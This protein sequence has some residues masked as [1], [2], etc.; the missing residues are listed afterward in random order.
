MEEQAGA[1]QP[2]ER[3]RARPRRE[4]LDGEDAARRTGGA[5]RRR[6]GGHGR[7]RRRQRQPGSA[8]R[9]SRRRCPSRCRRCPD[10][11]RR[12][13]PGCGIPGST[14]GRPIWSA[15]RPPPVPVR[16]HPDARERRD[17][18]AA[19]HRNLDDPVRVHDE[20]VV[21][22]HDEV[23]GRAEPDRPETGVVRYGN[24]GFGDGPGARSTAV[25]FVSSE[26]SSRPRPS[27]ARPHRVGRGVGEVAL[28]DRRADRR[29]A[30][31]RRC[32][33]CRRRGCPG[34][35]SPAR[36]ATGSCRRRR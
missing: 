12:R 19:R 11:C 30:R 5:G 22:G 1:A 35:R 20:Q 18:P 2:R 15:T 17:R 28:H 31:S 26:T 16:V 4:D 34:R 23:G 33:S 9:R 8:A 25:M 3:R 24:V 27:R 14:A 7:E 36:P 32:A 13:A 29:R 6:G 10:R 21:R